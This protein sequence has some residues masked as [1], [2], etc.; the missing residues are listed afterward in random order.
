V[1]ALLR[2]ESQDQASLQSLEERKQEGA[3]GGKSIQSAPMVTGGDPVEKGEPMEVPDTIPKP[4]PASKVEAPDLITKE[5]DDEGNKSPFF[6]KL[7]SQ[8]VEPPG[9]NV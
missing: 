6:E 8:T 5:S 9:Y 2:A 3:A 7:S 1:E 4:T